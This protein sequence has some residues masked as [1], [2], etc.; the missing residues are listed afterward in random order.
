[1]YR[2]AS[3]FLA[4]ALLLGAPAQAQTASAVEPDGRRE[5]LQR[6]LEDLERRIAHES[7]G[8]VRYVSPSTK[9]E[10]FKSY[11]ERFAARVE[12]IGTKRF[13][14]RD[15]KA[16]YG[17]VAIIVHVRPSGRVVNFEVLKAD[18]PL[19]VSS[20]KSLLS[21]IQPFEAFPP[22]MGKVQELAMFVQFNYARE[23]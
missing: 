2:I 19:L 15:G 22:S 6:Q 12:K 18:E 9:E 11:Y 5:Q 1:M 3:L 20:A 14:K 23:E 13:P 10:P 16:I 7:K 21:S 17:K 8:Q 4:Q